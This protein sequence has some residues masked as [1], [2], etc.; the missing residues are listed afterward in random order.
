[1][2]NAKAFV[3]EKGPKFRDLNFY[4]SLG[5]EDG[6]ADRPLIDQGLSSVEKTVEYAQMMERAGAQI[7]SVHGRL[8]EQRGVNSGLTDWDKIRAVKQAVKVPV[9]ANENTPSC[10]QKDNCTTLHCLQSLPRVLNDDIIAK[11]VPPNPVDPSDFPSY[12]VDVS[13]KT[14][15][16]LSTVKGHLF[17][18]MC[19]ALSYLKDLLDNLGKIRGTSSTLDEYV[20][21]CQEMKARMDKAT[22]SVDSNNLLELTKFDEAAGTKARKNA[23]QKTV[24]DVTNSVNQGLQ[25]VDSPKRPLSPIADPLDAQEDAKRAKH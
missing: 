18:I 7:V 6:Q 9:F 8:R 2:I 25:D 16:T 23:D 14:P 1:M 12:A 24:K 10:L 22:E 17:K 5:E 20:T 3:S 21:L 11:A 15:T 4:I 19:P 13:L